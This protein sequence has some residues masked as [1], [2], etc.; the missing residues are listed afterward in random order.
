MAK[1]PAIQFYTGDWLKD[2]VS[3]CSL[4]SQGLWLR[5][6]IVM[7]SSER[8]GYLQVNGCAMPPE[9]VARRCGCALAE[10]QTLLQEL[11]DAGVPSVTDDGIIYSRRMVRDHAARLQAQKDGKLGGNPK[12]LSPLN[13]S[14]I[15]PDKPTLKMKEKMKTS[16]NGEGLEGERALTLPQRRLLA[17]MEAEDLR[18]TK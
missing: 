7:H 3:G 8:Y 9:H 14:G 18:R 16:R 6:M 15:P 1:M 11:F 17:E 2:P 12:L 13:P 10:Y 4:A 5:M